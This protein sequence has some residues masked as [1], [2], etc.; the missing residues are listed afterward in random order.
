MMKIRFAEKSDQPAWDEYVN[1]HSGSNVYQKYFWGQSIRDVYK[2]QVYN[3]V[4]FQ[5]S[6]DG[7]DSRIVGLLPLVH[8]KHFLFGNTLFAMPFGDGG[9]VLADNQAI[10]TALVT[11]ACELAA[12]KNVQ[13]IELRQLAATD[14]GLQNGYRKQSHA[15]TK[16]RMVLDLPESSEQ[17]LASF[18][19]KLRSQIRRPLKD[20]LTVKS[21]GLELMPAFYKV[22]V[23]NMRDLGSPVH[24]KAFIMAVLTRA[25]DAKIFVV[26]KDQVPLACSFV[27]GHRDFLYN[28]WASSL[29]RY[30]RM[31]PNMLLYWSMFEYACERGFKSFD[32]GRS[33]LGEGTHKFKKQW[34]SVELPLHWISFSRVGDS[35]AFVDVNQRSKFDIAMRLWSKMP[36]FTTRIVGP[37]L[38]KN[39]GL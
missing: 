38:R 23:E 18:K 39:I 15:M 1:N 36:L 28:P 37:P 11:R 22:F 21:G 8:I 3:L 34:G 16:V 27:I 12:E 7:S 33:T 31:S 19:S 14:I 9:G 29:K 30:S 35:E 5:E 13:Q 25:K 2:H 17:L 20:G 26:Y 10:E 32:L 6:S 24:A 4:A